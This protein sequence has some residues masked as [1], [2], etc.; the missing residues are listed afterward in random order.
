MRPAFLEHVKRRKQLLEEAAKSSAGLVDASGKPVA[1]S[2]LVDASGKPVVSKLVDASGK[3]VSKR[4]DVNG[5][6]V[7]S[8]LLDANGEP[9]E[10]LHVTEDIDRAAG[11][12]KHAMRSASAAMENV[13]D[14]KEGDTIE[15]C[16]EASMLVQDIIMW[17]EETKGG[18]DGEE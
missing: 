9:I 14:A 6:P 15:V 5:K 18:A 17:L 8:T 10:R 2:K 1:A 12:S 7:S 11:R 4:V 16:P 13:Y 3:P